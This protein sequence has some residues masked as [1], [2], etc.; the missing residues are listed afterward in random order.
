[1]G[2]CITVSPAFVFTVWAFLLSFQGFEQFFSLKARQTLLQSNV[3]QGSERG[4]LLLC[5]PPFLPLL[6]S[7]PLPLASLLPGLEISCSISLAMAFRSSFLLSRHFSLRMEVELCTFLRN[8]LKS[9]ITSKLYCSGQ[10]FRFNAVPWVEVSVRL[11]YDPFLC[12]NHSRVVTENITERPYM[13]FIS[14]YKTISITFAGWRTLPPLPFHESRVP[15]IIC[16]T[17][18]N[19]WAIIIFHSKLWYTISPSPCV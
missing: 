9:K 4:P 7:P 3:R 17:N 6:L 5:L 16:L 2:L 12:A 8:W 1:M 18:I 15:V 10:R 11:Q 13:R 14:L 19:F